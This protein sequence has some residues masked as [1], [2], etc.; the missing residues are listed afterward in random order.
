MAVEGPG[1]SFLG[2]PMK[3]VS[4]VTVGRAVQKIKACFA[5]TS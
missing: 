3:H 2:V 1:A 4:L 5:D